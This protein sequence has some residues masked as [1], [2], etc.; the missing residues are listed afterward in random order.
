MKKVVVPALF[1]S[2]FF[3]V[4]PVSLR[5]EDASLAS[6]AD[7]AKKLDEVL[8]T[9]KKILEMLEQMKIDLNIAKIRA[10]DR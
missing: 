2:I 4:L 6:S 9:Q 8:L 5:A 3:L 1:L 7:T 10:S